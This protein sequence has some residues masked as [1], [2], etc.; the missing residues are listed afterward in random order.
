MKMRIV[1]PTRGRINRQRTFGFLSPE[2]RAN[3]DLV[4]PDKEAESHKGWRNDVN[5]VVQPDRDMTITKKRAW[6]MQHYAGLGY[7][8]IVMLDD[9]LEWFVRKE[10]GDWHLRQVKPEDMNYW[11]Q[12]LEN[13]LGPDI[14]HAGFG[15]RQGNNRVEPIW[16]TPDRQMY[17]LGY[18]LPVVLKECE[19][20]RIENREDMDITLQLLR[21]GYPNA[22]NHEI[23]GGQWGYGKGGSGGG[24]CAGQRTVET[25]NADAHK[26]AEFH[27]G[28]VRVVEK[29]Y[30]FSVPRL[31]VVCS[32]AKALRDGLAARQ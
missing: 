6:I 10:P 25:A 22:I 2:L 21:K 24:G 15:P 13:K 14:P 16:K 9:D 4:C 28:Y 23:C 32:W 3:T 17:T 8:K 18:Y 5:V 11:F 29:A 30:N 12:E 7:E 26:L 31:E 20:G 1:I 19:I 27:P